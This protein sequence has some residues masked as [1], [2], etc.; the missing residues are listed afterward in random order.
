MFAHRSGKRSLQQ[1]LP[2]IH[3]NA[4]S[5]PIRVTKQ[6]NLEGHHDMVHTGPRH[7]VARGSLRKQQEVARD[8]PGQHAGPQQQR[9][10]FLCGL[11]G[12][13][14]R[15][16]PLAAGRGLGVTALLPQQVQLG[17]GE[18]HIR[19]C[20]KYLQTSKVS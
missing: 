15:Q 11:H 20:V 9:L 3:S 18:R 7:T 8:G 19:H 12:M 2:V 16:G 10:T 5:C 4:A 17:I 6:W 14:E 1:A 13:E